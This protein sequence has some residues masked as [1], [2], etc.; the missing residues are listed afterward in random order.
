MSGG[1]LPFLAKLKDINP[2]GNVS[3][4]LQNEMRQNLKAIQV[5]LLQNYG[6]TVSIDARLNNIEANLSN[7]S[8]SVTSALNSINVINAQIVTINGQISTLSSQVTA[9]Q[10][11]FQSSADVVGYTNATATYTDITSLSITTTGKPLVLAFMPAT[12]GAMILQNTTA[13]A[14]SNLKLVRDVTD[15]GVSQIT[16][17]TSMPG[18]VFM[19]HPA[20]GTFTYKIQGN[21]P[22]PAGL[23]NI[24]F[25]RLV[26]IEV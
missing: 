2:S 14:A 17:L 25:A 23:L 26:A 4:Y 11:N 13:G 12:G 3:D 16:G 7:I 18:P 6:S 21:C 24:A 5:A 1:S 19:D 15:I 22:V 20:A 10:P 8:A 9:L